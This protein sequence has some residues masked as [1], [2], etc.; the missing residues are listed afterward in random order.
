MEARAKGNQSDRSQ[1]YRAGE[2]AKASHQGGNTGRAGSQGKHQGEQNRRNSRST[3]ILVGTPWPEGIEVD[4]KPAPQDV[5]DSMAV[6]LGKLFGGLL[7][8]F[9]A[10]GMIVSHEYILKQAFSLVQYGLAAMGVWAVGSKALKY[11]R[12]VGHNEN[13]SA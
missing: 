8:A 10:Y 6:G 5:K 1:L 12:T 4:V 11:V 13:K 3:K 7:I 9:V 2:M